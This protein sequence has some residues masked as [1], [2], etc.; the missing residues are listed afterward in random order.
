M[1]KEMKLGA[2]SDIWD[3]LIDGNWTPDTIDMMVKIFREQ[4][5][6]RLYI[7]YYGDYSHASLNNSD[8]LGGAQNIKKNSKRLQNYMPLFAEAGKRYGVE[9]ATVMRPLEQGT[10]FVYSPYYEKKGL[11]P[12][13]R[14]SQG[15][16]YI[17]GENVVASAFVR[18]HPELRIKRRSWDVDPNAEDKI[19]ASIKLYKQNNVPTRIKKENIEIYTSE[20]NSFYQKYEGDF[21]FQTSTE[22]AKETVILGDTAP[23][24]ITTFLTEKDAPIQVLTLGGLSIQEKYV[25]IKVRC[26]GQLSHNA[27]S[28]SSDERFINT[29]VNGIACF[30][31]DGTQICA[32][33][34]QNYATWVRPLNPPQLESGFAF[35][36]GFG[37]H[38]P[39]IFDPDDED[40][41][42]AIAKGKEMY[43]HTALCE[44]EPAVQEYF[45]SMLEVALEN[46]CDLVGN[47]IENHA[48]HVD[49]PFAYGYNDCIKEEYFRR[50]GKCEEKEME[51]D[52]IAKIRGDAW[53]KLFVEGAK[54]VRAKG[55]KVYLTLNIEMLQNPIP[56]DR[57]YAYPMTVEWQW[58]R[59]LE[60]IRPD[61]INF[62]TFWNTP[63]F[64]LT[65]PQCRHMLEVA[66]S[67]NVPLTFE[68]YNQFEF[69]EE[70]K[71]MAATGLFDMMLNYETWNL[72]KCDENGEI[73]LTEQGKRQFEQLH[74]IVSVKG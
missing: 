30:E 36:D 46:G 65:N 43:V 63:N 26:N 64:F 20:D 42:I 10:W 59:W 74:N 5:V 13:P 22:R 27:S 69:V 12:I 57:R 4:G 9:I 11:L 45:L 67:Y 71:Q 61:E 49:E 72:L 14:T 23:D 7:Q 48:V 37:E 16:P 39:I 28:L 52:K 2:V 55:K 31:A 3:D 62:R 58:E 41:F 47:R 1:Q 51:L 50:Y 6:S 17:G 19:I 29:A 38:S 24:Y 35:N 44:C 66:K 68:R 40:G 34:G 8:A 15:I 18:E 60:E 33:P 56:I 32:T 73:K 21:T 53:T 54:R 25:A 70:F